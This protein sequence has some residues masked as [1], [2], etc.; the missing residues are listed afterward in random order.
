[1]GNLQIMVLFIVNLMGFS[2]CSLNNILINSLHQLNEKKID[3]L[4]RDKHSQGDCIVWYACNFLNA[5]G[6]LDSHFA[7]RN[8]L[9]EREK[10]FERS[11]TGRKWGIRPLLLKRNMS[12]KHGL[13]NS[14]D[15]LP[16]LTRAAFS[17]K[18]KKTRKV[19]TQ[20]LSDLSG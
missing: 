14:G 2:T 19:E 5:L 20:R 3:H 6:Q 11:T 13:K 8:F 9:N 1:M 15:S 7:D 12:L 18:K 4:D 16:L 17:K 10:N